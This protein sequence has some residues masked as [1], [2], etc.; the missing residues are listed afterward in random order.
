[1]VADTKSH[2]WRDKYGL[3]HLQALTVVELETIVQRILNLDHKLFIHKDAMDFLKVYMD[4][5]KLLITWDPRGYFL[6]SPISV[7]R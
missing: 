1:M 5:Y 3:L 6:Y 2:P 7:K 4:D